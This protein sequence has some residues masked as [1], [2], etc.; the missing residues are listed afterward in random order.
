MVNWY[1][2][3]LHNDYDS[4]ISIIITTC[5]GTQSSALPLAGPLLRTL[6]VESSRLNSIL[7]KQSLELALTLSLTWKQSQTGRDLPG[8][9]VRVCELLDPLCSL[10]CFSA[11]F[12]FSFF[13]ANNLV[14]FIWNLRNHS[15]L[16]IKPNCLVILRRISNN[17]HLKSFG[18]QIIWY[19]TVVQTS[20]FPLKTQWS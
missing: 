4:L 18:S 11:G 3:I 5:A 13:E 10:G 17:I 15:P 9:A 8:N 20:L 16:D 19:T 6:Q 14:T 1:I 2:Q 7:L 12:V